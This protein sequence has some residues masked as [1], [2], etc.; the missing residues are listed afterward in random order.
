MGSAAILPSARQTS[1]SIPPARSFS[2]ACQKAIILPVASDGCHLLGVGIRLKAALRASYFP[3]LTSEN[4]S[5]LD[6]FVTPFN[7]GH[8]V[9]LLF[10]LLFEHRYDD[11]Q[12]SP[13]RRSASNA[14]Q[15]GSRGQLS[16]GADPSVD[17]A[18]GLKVG[19][20]TFLVCVC[21]RSSAR[22]AVGCGHQFIVQGFW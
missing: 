1:R 4:G 21:D 3:G 17:S 11:R 15:I 12:R 2:F 16:R 14:R 19:A 20:A 13:F 5:R 10:R 8:R 9:T 7:L 6:G 22:F 18:N